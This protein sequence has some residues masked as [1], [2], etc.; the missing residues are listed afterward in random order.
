MLD[1][2]PTMVDPKP[3]PDWI[4]WMW[5]QQNEYALQVKYCI[6]QMEQGIEEQTPHLQ[7]YVEFHKAKN[8]TWLK[9]NFSGTAHFE[10]R[11]GTADQARDYCRKTDTRTDGPWEW[12]T[13]SPKTPGQRTD[14]QVYQECDLC[15]QMFLDWA[16]TMNETCTHCHWM[17]HY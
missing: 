11:K 16:S 7:G 17:R 5:E 4:H 14:I 3:H 13:W 12:G 9:R 10:S 1:D 6:V 8:L 2:D 15:G